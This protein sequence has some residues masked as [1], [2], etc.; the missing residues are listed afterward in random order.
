CFCLT[1]TLVVKRAGNEFLAR[2]GLSKNQDGRI[3]FGNGLNLFQDFLQRRAFSNDIAEVLVP[4]F[5]LKVQFLFLE[6]ILLLF[7]PLRFLLCCLET[8]LSLQSFNELPNLASD[9]VEQVE[10]LLV[11]LTNFVAKEFHYSDDAWGYTNWERERAMQ[12]ILRRCFRS[13]KVRI[14]NGVGQPVGLVRAPNASGKADTRRKCRFSRH[15]KE[16]G[17]VDRRNVPKLNA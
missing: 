14:F 15:G 4:D 6:P 16:C 1:V 5:F 13:W 8:R 11:G 2:A 9:R 17:G 7:D 3:S 10:Y 12:P